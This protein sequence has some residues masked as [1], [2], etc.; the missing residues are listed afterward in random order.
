MIG[1]TTNLDDALLKC[2]WPA[3][4]QRF[5]AALR[6]A[7]VYILGR[8]NPLGIVAAGTIVRGTPDRSSDLDIYVINEKPIRQR[9]QRFFDDVPAEIFVNPAPSIRK[10]FHDEHANGRPSTAHM[11]ATGW[12]VMSRD[13][14]VQE[15]KNEAAEWLAKPTDYAPPQLLRERYMAATLYEDARDVADRDSATAA[16]LL[17]ESVTAMLHYWYRA[18]DMLIPRSKELVSTIVSMDEGLGNLFAEFFMTTSTERRWVL[19]ER[20]ADRTIGVRG[21]FEWESEPETAME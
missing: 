12:I 8:F 13:K 2:Q 1:M 5:D 3:L 6:T 19:A 10:Y 4:P 21:F 20:I 14:V 7:T 17:N 11:L 15:L 18:N 9:I 16:L